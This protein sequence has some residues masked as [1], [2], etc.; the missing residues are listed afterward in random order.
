MTGPTA[1]RGPGRSPRGRPATGYRSDPVLTARPAWRRE[2][3]RIIFEHDTPAGRA[4][5]VLLIVAILASVAAVMLESVDPIA[6]RYGEGLR[7]AEWVFTFLFT[8][9]YITRL[10]AARRAGRYARSFFGVVDLLAI[11]PT[12]LSLVVPGG[13]ALAVIRILR[14]LRVFRVFKLAQF[15]G[16][17]RLMLVALRQSA[18]KIAVF[19][20]AVLSIVTVVGSLMYFVEGP[21]HGFTSIPRG[22]YWAIVTVTTVGFGD[23]TPATIPGQL[24]A[25]ALMVVGY[26][27]IAVPTGIVTAEMLGTRASLRETR[28]GSPCDACG[29]AGHEPDAGYCRGCG[30][31]LVPPGDPR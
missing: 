31:A 17:E 24:I 15:V 25:A 23:I 19:L 1:P 5:D 8:V 18:Y 9:E 2:L 28:R 12:Y 14:V 13:Q 27:I 29:L 16:S 10:A 3:Y 7:T 21:E 20:V 26:G 11:L 30:A 22:I 4:F 6:L